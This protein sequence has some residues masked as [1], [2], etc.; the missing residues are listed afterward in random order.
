M[1]PTSGRTAILIL[2]ARIEHGSLTPLRAGVRSNNDVAT[3][4]SQ[5]IVLTDVNDVCDAV[6]AWLEVLLASRNAGVTDGRDRRDLV[7]AAPTQNADD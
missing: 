5:T 3:D 2:R 1:A 6:R 7:I 4:L